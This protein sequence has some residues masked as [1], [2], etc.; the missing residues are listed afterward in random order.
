L[1]ILETRSPAWNRNHILAA[2]GRTSF[3]PVSALLDIA[4]NSASAQAS[5]VAITVETESQQGSAGRPKHIL[6]AFTIADNGCGMDVVG[7]DNAL[8]LGPNAEVMAEL[9]PEPPVPFRSA[10]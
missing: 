8:S 6:K 4:D 1:T 10:A 5:K 7:L 2:I 9:R 3:Q